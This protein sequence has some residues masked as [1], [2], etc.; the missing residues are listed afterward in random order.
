MASGTAAPVDELEGVLSDFR[1]TL[2][3]D[4]NS[5]MRLYENESTGPGRAGGW[6][7]ALTR[8]ALVLLAAN[9]ENFVETLVC[10]SLKQLAG[11]SVVARKY[12]QR[13]RHWLF[14]E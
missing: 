6:M 8:S 7:D 5:L 1:R 10:E 12:P 2:D 4:V 3:S 13:F 9:F 11:Q 14:H